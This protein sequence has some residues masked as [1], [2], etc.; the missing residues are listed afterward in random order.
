LALQFPLVLQNGPRNLVRA[1]KVVPAYRLPSELSANFVLDRQ[2]CNCVRRGFDQLIEELQ[3]DFFGHF[4]ITSQLPTTLPRPRRRACY[5]RFAIQLVDSSTLVRL[6]RSVLRLGLQCR[7][8]GSLAFVEGLG[9]CFVPTIT[10]PS[11]HFLRLL[12]YSLLSSGMS[13]CEKV[14]SQCSVVQ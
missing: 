8:L 2:A 1:R 11:K 13:A 7:V 9:V 10:Q 12:R 3:F 5:L 6:H 14:P 4:G